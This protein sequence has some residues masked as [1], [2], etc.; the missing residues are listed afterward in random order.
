MIH[1]KDIKTEVEKIVQ[2]FRIFD[3]AFAASGADHQHFVMRRIGKLHIADSDIIRA[4]KCPLILV[5][6]EIK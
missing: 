4:L 1:N 2:N 5:A 6:P 3:V